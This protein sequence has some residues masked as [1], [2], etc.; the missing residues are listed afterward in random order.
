MAFSLGSTPVVVASDPTIAREI[1]SSASFADRP[2]KQSAKNLMF[3]RAIG[4]AP[5]GTYWRLLR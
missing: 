2:V 4:F 1:L 5:N 3:T